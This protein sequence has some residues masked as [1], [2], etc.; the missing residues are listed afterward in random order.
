MA[1]VQL[2]SPV[3]QPRAGGELVYNSCICNFIINDCIRLRQR[4]L[5]DQA[6]NTSRPQR[7]SFKNK[8]THFCSCKQHGCRLSRLVFCLRQDKP[9]LSALGRLNP[10]AVIL[11]LP[12]TIPDRIVQQEL[13]SSVRLSHMQGLIISSSSGVNFQTLVAVHPCP[14]VPV[15]F[16]RYR[17]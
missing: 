15:V 2:I 4:V 5:A 8:I 12:A 14:V 17:C 6:Y 16:Q 10:F 11:K 9:T 7:E 1:C 3:H 13:F